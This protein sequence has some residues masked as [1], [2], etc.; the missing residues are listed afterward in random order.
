M[1][2]KPA[3]TVLQEA[4]AFIFRGGYREISLSSLSTGD[5]RGIGSLV[6]ALNAAYGKHRV[7]FQL[8]SLK[9]SSFSLPLL[10]EI[11]EVRRS[12]LTFAVET[13]SG[14]GQIGLNKSVS[15]D[16]VI[17]I[18]REAR[19]YGWKGA[20]FYFMIGLPR[21]EPAESGGEALE[22]ADFIRDIAG[23]TGM[24][25]NINVGTFVPKPHT[26]YQRMPQLGEAEAW[27]RLNYIRAVLK[28][29]GHKVGIQ[30]PFISAIEGVISRGDERTGGLIED[31]CAAGCRL[32]AW[33]EYIR[34]DLWR[35]LFERYEPLVREVLA[36]IPPERTL[37]WDGIESG[38]SSGYIDR[39][40][41]KSERR[42]ATPICASDCDH[43]CG[44]CGGGA[45]IA[46][47]LEE[48]PIPAKPRPL[49]PPRKPETDT[50]RM[51]FAFTKKKSAV[52][53]P[54]LAVAEIFS[55]A[56]LR[57]NIPISYSQGFN[58]LP[59]LEI[60]SPLSVGVEADAEI[61]AVDTEVSV[62]PEDFAAALNP[63]LPEGFRVASAS[64][65]KIPFGVKKYSLSSL[66]W[67]YSYQSASEPAIPADFVPAKDEK[68]YR[69]AKTGGSVY[70]LIRREVLAKS[71]SDPSQ[72]ASYFAVCRELY[73]LSPALP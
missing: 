25:F 4:E 3:G 44:V 69:L 72:P 47:N 63:C 34:K 14:S 70:G 66:L 71:L 51:V 17:A 40:A 2:Q 59:R 68:A 46:E 19:K 62:S 13:P 11:S 21:L 29:L 38:I 27:R 12:G 20:K 5:Y 57:G 39:E 41:L 55:M 30:D 31:A 54:H 73:P 8:P 26:P 9:V 65:L 58:P 42:E 22:I 15:R 48:T 18:L 28:P 7:S 23:K 10:A 35:G 60:A 43:P 16:E 33:T 1:R 36:G 53:Q 6:Y 32:D 45:D 24:R 37:P 56:F 49:N 50:Y 52:F 61:A 64:A 67:G